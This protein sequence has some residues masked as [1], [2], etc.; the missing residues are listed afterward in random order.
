MLFGIKS[1]QLVAVYFPK[2]CHREKSEID[3][4]IYNQ[5]MSFKEDLLLFSHS[6][7]KLETRNN[8][9]NPCRRRRG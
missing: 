3:K 5:K 1:I 4:L 7:D 9:F 8:W 2:K 6:E